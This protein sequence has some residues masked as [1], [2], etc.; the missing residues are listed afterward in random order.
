M[1]INGC[2]WLSIAINYNLEKK[3]VT[4]LPFEA[5]KLIWIEFF[6]F[7]RLKFTYNVPVT[8]TQ[9]NPTLHWPDFHFNAKWNRRSPKTAAYVIISPDHPSHW[10][11]FESAIIFFL[12]SH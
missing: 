11:K 8:S 10:G 12:N 5:I 3:V 6:A 1:N 4:P 9:R 7:G 2:I